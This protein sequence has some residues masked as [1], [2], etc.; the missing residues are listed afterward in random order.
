MSL[1]QLLRELRGGR[2]VTA[3]CQE[4]G[5]ASRQTIYTWEGPRSR[6]EPED[7]ARLLQHYGATQEQID[8]ALRLRAG[9]APDQSVTGAA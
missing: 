5:I 7:L 6:P 4:L 1:G 2:S 8:L 3:V 9:I